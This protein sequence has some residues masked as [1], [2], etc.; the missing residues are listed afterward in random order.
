MKRPDLH[1]SPGGNI[2]GFTSAGVQGFNEL[3]PSAIV[4]ELIQNSLDA[5]REDGRSKAVVHFIMESIELR[6][7][8]GL[9]NYQRAFEAA[10]QDQTSLLSDELPEQAAMVVDTIRGC[11]NKT[12][13]DTLSV[14]DNGVGLNK[15]RM[16]GLLA[17]GM[18]VKSSSGSGTVGNGHLTAI[19]SSDLRYVLYG[20]V[21]GGGKIASGHAVLATFSHKGKP[22]SKDGYYALAVR[23]SLANRYEFP[24]EKD[25]PPLIRE[26]LDWIDANSKPKT[27]TAVI[28]PGFN[29][30]REQN[31]N[32]WEVI[33]NAA[34]CSFFAAIADGHLE[35]S[36]K[37]NEGEKVL[38][39]SNI[40]SVFA[41]GLATEV[42]TK[43][44]L[45][46][47]RAAEA[48]E[49][50]TKG[51]GH[52]I[53]VGCG[54]VDI[55]IREVANGPSQINLCRNGMWITGKLPRMRRDK[56]SERKPFHCLLKVTAQDGEIH[57]L[58]RKSE[59]PLHNHLETRKWLGSDERQKLNNA[60]DTIAK[61][62]LDNT[63][64]L[65]NEEFSVIDFLAV[66]SGG[67]GIST[68]GR[69]N[70]KI[71][72]FDEVNPR[73]P[74]ATKLGANDP[75]PTPDP[76]PDPSPPNPEPKPTPPDPRPFK[77]QGNA[78]EFGAVPVP[79]G[80]R[81]YSIELHPQES[82]SS[83]VEAEIRFVLDENIDETCDV[84]SAE[85]YVALK[86]VKF[87][88][89]KIPEHNLI[90]TNKAVH[91]VRLGQ[92]KQGEVSTLDFSYELPDDVDAQESDQVVLR[93]EIVR[94]KIG[95]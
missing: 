81:S 80:T 76:P 60:L 94:R 28:I 68:G 62:L 87:D 37:D 31:I 48:Y 71:G 11:L 32:L 66:T 79:T 82:M 23:E 44:F 3:N 14:L 33:S 91:G 1:F 12:G 63:D 61:F 56:F 75:G 19:P 86:N 58:I 65:K 46:G 27:G 83:D 85:S 70:K 8:P 36:Y 54:E 2:E 51:K 64:E 13:I 55:L 47:K 24:A 78:I 93:A 5:V 18:S 35:V 22:M 88:G 52:R 67:K 7:L 20:G 92:L 43:N 25:I 84:S 41:S 9:G 17:D 69:R 50:A 38:D 15:Q 29:K 21:S 95:E 10:V 90:K 30:F 39:K 49:T 40:V 74:R 59:G 45:S 6:D 73:P 42:S 72:E 34:A 26:K 77:R 57:K 4:R 53:D 16:V 89:E